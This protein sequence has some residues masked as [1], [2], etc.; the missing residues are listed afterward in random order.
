[1][2]VYIYT[3]KRIYVPIIYMY[4]CVCVL[5]LAGIRRLVIQI[6]AI[7]IDVLSKPLCAFSLAG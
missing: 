4:A 3:H 2:Y 5:A 1:M 6:K 7:E